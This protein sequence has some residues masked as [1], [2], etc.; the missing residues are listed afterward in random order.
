MSDL[1]LYAI[2]GLDR[3][4]PSPDL[5]AQL[6]AQL[7]TTTDQITRQRLDV[8]RAILGDPQR[9]QAYDAQLAD[10]AAPPITEAVLAD[11]AGRP[12]PVQARPFA[13]PRVMAALAAFLGVLLVVVISA[14]ACS[15]GDDNRSTSTVGA[16][17]S[18]TTAASGADDYTCWVDD[19]EA[20]QRRVAR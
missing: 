1:D 2:H 15:G 18:T 6:T 4:A 7:N 11:L 17:G 10:P 12:A 5:A 9:R 16:D 8:A 3:R 20:G 19:R 13:Q 14:V